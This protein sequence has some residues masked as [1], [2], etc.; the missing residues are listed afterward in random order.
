M[1]SYSGSDSSGIMYRGNGSIPEIFFTFGIPQSPFLFLSLPN[2]CVM[3][4]WLRY[5]GNVLPDYLYIMNKK[6]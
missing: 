4:A 6:N 5:E 2:P 3:L 1:S